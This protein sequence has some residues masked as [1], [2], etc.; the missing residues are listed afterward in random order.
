M[1][2]LRLCDLYLG[3]CMT[4]VWQLKQVAFLLLVVLFYLPINARNW[5]HRVDDPYAPEVKTRFLDETKEYS[6]KSYDFQESTLF[7]LFDYNHFQE[8]MLPTSPI[9]LRNKPQETVDGAALSKH[10]EECYKELIKPRRS[11]RKL[12]KVK[13]LKKNNFNFKK[14]NGLA[15]FKLTEPPYDNFVVKLFIE[16]PCDFVRPYKKDLEQNCLFPMGGGISRYLVGF[17]RIKN[18]HYIRSK[19]ATSPYWST[20]VDMPRKW[21]WIPPNC[22]WFEVKGYNVGGKAEQSIKL[23]SVYAIVCDAVESDRAFSKYDPDDASLVISL[24]RWLGERLDPNIPNYMIEKDTGK[25]VFVD[26]EHFPSNVGLTEPLD[27][28]NHT[29]W[30]V[31]VTKKYFKDNFFRTKKERIAMKNGHAK[32]IMKCT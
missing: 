17:T 13:L 19:I 2:T 18:L 10:I 30:M 24:V 3:Y 20:R 23:P 9:T 32:R 22:R 25:V 27:Y 7:E 12:K 14:A 21:F 8:N 11:I 1:V 5:Q 28:D 4:F 6:L 16:K 26:T 15:I 29:Q 31:K